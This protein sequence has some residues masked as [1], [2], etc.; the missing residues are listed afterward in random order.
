MGTLPPPS[1]RST[2]ASSPQRHWRQVNLREQ[3][4]G[5]E[6]HPEAHRPW[7][8]LHGQRWTEHLR[9]PE[10]EDL[11]EDHHR[12]LRPVL[13]SIREPL[14]KRRASIFDAASVIS[15]LLFWPHFCTN[16]KVQ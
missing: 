16:S 8:A 10:W 2:L 6:L 4:R 13:G 14:K 12:R 5:R 1:S 7:S 11:Q 3:V 9:L 15:F